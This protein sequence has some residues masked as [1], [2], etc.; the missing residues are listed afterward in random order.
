MAHLFTIV[1]F[2]AACRGD[3]DA[4]NRDGADGCCACG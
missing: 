3:V 2:A 1:M 4:D